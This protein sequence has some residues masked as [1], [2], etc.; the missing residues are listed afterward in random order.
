MDE[1]AMQQWVNEIF[2]MYLAANP[3]PEGVIP[4]LFLDS[5]RC[6]M[7]ASV[8]SRIEAMGI[9]VIHIPG[10]CMGLCQPLDVGVNRSFK[11]RIR[12]MWE[13]WLTD[14]LEQTDKVRDATRKEV[15]EWMAAVFWEMVGSRVLR[16]CWRKTGY[17]WFPGL[18]ID[19]DD[20]VAAST[21][22]GDDG[23]DGGDGGNGNDGGDDDSGNNED[24]YA[25][26]ELLFDSD[27]E[28]EES[29]DDDIEDEGDD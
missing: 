13:E 4:V 27:E 22:D 25:Y 29:N 11:A 5:Y 21:G 15:S 10:G 14:L 2:G 8:V 16:N 17:D 12:R 6:H 26:D 7:I 19:Q 18:L 23:G 24:S 28:G 9:E 3:P 1:R 20:V